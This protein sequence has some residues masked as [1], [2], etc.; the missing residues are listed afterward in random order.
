MDAVIAWRD[1][2]GYGGYAWLIADNRYAELAADLLVVGSHGHGGFAGMLL[3][4][5]S[6]HCVHHSPC[7]VVVV[8]EHHSAAA[9]Q[10]V[11]ADVAVI[12]QPCPRPG[13][14]D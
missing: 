12:Q 2:A 8:R 9:T 6:Q 11:V 3:G 13:S 7:P 1:P 10:A 4:S 14:A 5:V